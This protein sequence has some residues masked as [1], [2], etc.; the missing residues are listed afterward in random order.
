M[1]R[2][3]ISILVVAMFFATA[4]VC[5]TPQSEAKTIDDKISCNVGDYDYY[6]GKTYTASQGDKINSSYQKHMMLFEGDKK[7]Q[8]IDAINNGKDLKSIG[9]YV[10]VDSTMN[11][12]TYFLLSFREY[13]WNVTVVIDSTTT[14]YESL[15]YIGKNP[16][17]YSLVTIPVTD[18]SKVSITISSPTNVD[19]GGLAVIPKTLKRDIDFDIKYNGN[20][21]W[22]II[23]NS[24]DALL[25]TDNQLNFTG[26]KVTD[27]YLIIFSFNE[28]HD[29][30]PSHVE[31][32]LNITGAA[33]TSKPMSFAILF[34]V[35]AI[36][37]VAGIVYLAK[38]KV[39]E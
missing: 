31:F 32:N 29:C 17:K 23:K 28:D 6:F 15:D 39:I 36:A 19:Y 24:D 11:A 4:L 25:F 3:I 20:T 33:D 13:D 10:A 22:N 9:G 21:V 38:K 35:L 1:N 27:Y 7:S 30:T 26:D 18:G 5:I 37:V 8:I 12:G 2:K 14:K 16:C 34:F